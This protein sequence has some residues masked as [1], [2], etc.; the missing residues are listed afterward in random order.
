VI[1]DLIAR[2]HVIGGGLRS[3]DHRWF[4]LSI[5]KNASSYTTNI[6]LRNGW[7]HW[8]LGLGEFETVIIPL[9]DPV[10]RWVSGTA[11]YCCSYLLG[12][13]YGSEHFCTD[14]NELV[15]RVI[16]DTMIFDDHTTPQSVFVG[17]VP[18]NYEK[19]YVWVDRSNFFDSMRSITGTNIVE[20]EGVY[21]NR[22]DSNIDISRI[23]DLLKQR[24]NKSIESRIKIKYSSDYD[25][26][27]SVAIHGKR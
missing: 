2:G 13:N 11:T 5:P 20:H 17:F 23:S 24:L 18:S 7:E 6:L 16:V 9:R 8:N 22:K 10:E 15:E 25:M 19:T 26:I 1:T 12:A 3:P 4:V 27:G 21:D 14:Y